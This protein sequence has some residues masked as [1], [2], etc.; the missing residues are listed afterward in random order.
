MELTEL[1][2][3]ACAVVLL[4]PTRT[5][6]PVVVPTVMPKVTFVAVAVTAPVFTWLLASALDGTPAPKVFMLR[7][8]VATLPNAVAVTE[9][10]ANVAFELSAAAPVPEFSANE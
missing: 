4:P 5:A 6:E 10:F 1:L 3:T 2:P 7:L 8:F 9:L